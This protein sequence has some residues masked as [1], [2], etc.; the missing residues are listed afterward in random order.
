MLNHQDINI[1]FIARHSLK[2]EMKKLGVMHGNEN[3]GFLGFAVKKNGPLGTHVRGGFGVISDWPQLQR[4]IYSLDLSLS[5][6]TDSDDFMQNGRV[7]IHHKT[8]DVIEISLGSKPRKGIQEIMLQKD[9]K[10][11]KQ[12]KMQDT[13]A[14]LKGVDYLLLQDI[15]KNPSWSDSLVQSWYKIKHNVVACNYALSL[16]YPATSPICSLDN[17]R[18]E[19]MAHL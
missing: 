12:L 14:D 17:N 19:S 4:L 7:L 5:W 18:C 8:D 11:F 10:E 2:I 13:L 16:W 3:T 15:F 1:R 6:E 9:L